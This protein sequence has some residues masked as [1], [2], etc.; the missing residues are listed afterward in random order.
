MKERGNGWKICLK[1]YILK[2]GEMKNDNDFWTKAP[3][4]KREIKV[5]G[6]ENKR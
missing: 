6:R 5:N 4:G 1:L 3:F 2:K